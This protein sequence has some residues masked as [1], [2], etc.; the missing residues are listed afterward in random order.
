MP[1]RFE[2]FGFVFCEAAAYGVPPI[3]RIT[4][5]VGEIIRDGVN[6]IGLP[7]DASAADFAE[8]IV[9]LFRDH[10]AYARTANAARADFETRLNWDVFARNAIDRMNRDRARLAR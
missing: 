5:G 2:A 3:S 8:R 7:A 4:G 10:E 1:S 9:A 6:G